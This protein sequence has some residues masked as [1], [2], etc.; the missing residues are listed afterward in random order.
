ML[1]VD[2]GDTFHG[3]GTGPVISQGRIISPLVQAL[4]I[5]V[6]VPGNRDFAYGPGRLREF[7]AAGGGTAMA[8]NVVDGEDEEKT[9]GPGGIRPCCWEVFW[10]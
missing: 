6:L 3:T 4:R 2:C 10:V 8:A 5:A 7:F 9:N 1:L